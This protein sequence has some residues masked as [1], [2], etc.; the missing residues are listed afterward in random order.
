[1]DN[2][3]KKF[4]KSVLSDIQAKIQDVSHELKKTY[5]VV[6]LNKY[7]ASCGLCSRRKAEDEIKQGFVTVNHAVITNPGYRVQEK[8]VVR[9]KKHEVKPEDFVYI[10]LN[11]PDGYVTTVSDPHNKKT[12]MQLIESSVVGDRRLFPVGRL[13][14]HTTGLLLITND[15]ELS[16]QLAHPK[17]GA[18]KMYQVLLD[19][20][21]LEKDLQKI[22]DGINLDD[23]FVSSD[24]AY[25]ISGGSKRRVGI[26]IHTG[27][28]RIIR[29]IFKFLGYN[30]VSLDRVAYAGLS[31]HGLLRGQWRFLMPNEVVAL[32][33]AGKATTMDIIKS[34][35]ESKSVARTRPSRPSA[36]V[37][38][39]WAAD[40]ARSSRPTNKEKIN[41]A[42][43]KVPSSQ[44][45]DKEKSRRSTGKARPGR[46]T[47]KDNSSWSTDNG[48]SSRPVGK[49]RSGQPIDKDNS[50]WSIDKA[51]PSRPAGKAKPSRSTT[52]EKPSWTAAKAR[53]KKS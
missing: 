45:I 23:G 15:G 51:K 35:K 47:N 31:K 10:L 42:V 5:E 41:W 14:L 38:S 2:K 46:P 48:K 36:T 19:Q 16:Q 21:L 12:V 39:R 44:P 28:N 8:D 37:R 6:T 50:S 20:P 1:M 52:K 49:K 27:K 43:G 40:K 33:H 9:Y 34:V 3:V 18:Q 32:R 4:A 11:K 26:Q 24:R 53:F 22:R 30:V 7:L 17:N 29:R 25:Y 13:D